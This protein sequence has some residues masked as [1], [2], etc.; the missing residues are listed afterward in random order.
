M[1]KIA[2]IGLGSMGRNHYRILKSL[3]S[4][5]TLVG[6][7]DISPLEGYDE[8]C[9]T[10]VEA[11][12]SNTKPDGVIISA[13]TS[14]HKDIALRCIEA[15][16]AI[17]IEKPAASSVE[18]A[19]EILDAV[20]RYGVK[21]CIGHVE[22]FNPVV[23]ALQNELRGRD[24]YTISIT[25]V[26]PFPP[27]IAD[28]GVLTDLSVH[29]IDLMRYISHKNIVDKA[30]FKSQKIHNHHEDNAVLSFALEGN[31]VANILTNWLTPFKKRII[32]VACKEVY[33]EADLITQNLVEYSGYSRQN[34]YVVRNCHIKKDEPLL[35]EL[36]AFIHYLRTGER[37][38]LATIE[39]SIITLEVALDHD[40]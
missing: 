29:D 22:R 26:G 4:E 15:G 12:L 31:I 17:F 24:I 32:E 6:L 14:L 19:R 1:M 2:I 39:D 16:V 35:M 23:Q 20:E 13:P 3:D 38:S 10:E 30:V 36:E 28:V 27:R 40:R 34:S 8:P 33:L 7:C 18:D 25:R 5:C 9:F 11:L 37:G 21:S